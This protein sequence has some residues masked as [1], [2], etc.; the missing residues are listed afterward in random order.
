M[1]TYV[2]RKGSPRRKIQ[3]RRN[4]CITNLGSMETALGILYDHKERKYVKWQ[5]WIIPVILRRHSTI[6][7]VNRNVG[8]WCT[9]QLHV[10]FRFALS[11]IDLFWQ[12]VLTGRIF[13]QLSGSIEYIFRKSS[14][15]RTELLVPPF[16]RLRWL[17]R[18]LRM[19][20]PHH[21]IRKPTISLNA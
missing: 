14:I 7:I 6:W 5:D 1:H 12:T 2:L 10:V 8:R 11:W 19:L 4:R 15:L 16:L 20:R 9:M 18:V 3:E 17:G 13:H 21:V